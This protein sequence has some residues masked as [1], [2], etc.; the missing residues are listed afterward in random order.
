MADAANVRFGPAPGQSQFFSNDRRAAILP[1][2]PYPKIRHAV[3]GSSHDGGSV[4]G[5][6]LR[7]DAVGSAGYEV[8]HGVDPIEVHCVSAN[9]LKIVVDARKYEVVKRASFRDQCVQHLAI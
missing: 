3:A 9:L 6:I 7:F 5:S 4:R 2:A 8:T 1:L